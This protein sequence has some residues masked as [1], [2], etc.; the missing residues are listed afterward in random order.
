[1]DSEF[2]TRPLLALL[3]SGVQV[4]AVVKPLGG[5]S[6]RKTNVA[7]RVPSLMTR[8]REA[9]MRLLTGAAPLPTDPAGVPED[10]FAVAEAWGIPCYV[11]G[12]ASGDRAH[13]VLSSLDVDVHCVAFFN[14][15]LRRNVLRLPRLGTVN[16]HPS[17][18]PAYRGPAPLFWMF[19]DAV[20]ETGV[21]LHLVAPGEDDGDVLL[22]APMVLEDG[23]RGPDLLKHMAIKGA[24]LMVQGVWALHRGD[25]KP[26]HQDASRAFRSPRPGGED[27]RVDF[28]RPARD[29]FNFVRGVSQWMPL[30]AQVGTDRVDVLDALHFEAGTTLPSEV[31]YTGNTLLARCADGMV[32]LRIRPRSF[33]WNALPLAADPA[34]P[35]SEK[36]RPDAEK[37][38]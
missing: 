17:L 1:M 36:P 32:A 26:V 7:S 27:L 6:L 12:D 29:V 33:P 31:A 16:L 30:F 10:P 14:Q 2:S 19:K 24:D 28:T 3:N 22:Q 35:T 11:V 4:K 18:L 9:W 34:V 38:R 13:R 20:R 8:L 23:T 25:A 5:V 37:P 21:T 15:L